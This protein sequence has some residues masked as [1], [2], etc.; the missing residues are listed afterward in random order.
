MGKNLNGKR[1]GKLVVIGEADDYIQP[2]GRRRSRV[3]CLCDC[4]NTIDVLRENVVSGKTKSCGCYRRTVS[5]NARKSHG[6]SES[7]L[8][9]VWLSMKRRCDNENVPHYEDYGKRGITVCDEWQHS[10]ESFRDWAMQNGYHEGLSIDRINNDMGYS[11]TNCRWADSKTQ[12]NNRRSN[13]KLTYNGETH[14]V[15]EWAELLGINPKTLFNRIYRGL[16]I[17]HI[18]AL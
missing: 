12:A 5:S 13:R 1:F 10:Y 17:E 16:D 8:Y 6:D 11:P 18:L 2:N 3:S 7:L 14:N 15:T 4:G 9:G